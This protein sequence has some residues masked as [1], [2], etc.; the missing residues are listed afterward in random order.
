MQNS[1]TFVRIFP[2]EPKSEAINLAL[3]R[4]ALAL[5]NRFIRPLYTTCW[6]G[7]TCDAQD[8]T[9]VYALAFSLFIGVSVF[10]N[11]LDQRRKTMLT[12]R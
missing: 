3:Q 7:N 4:F 11:E 5:K 1:T 6:T 2:L 8:G 9:H 12:W 10:E